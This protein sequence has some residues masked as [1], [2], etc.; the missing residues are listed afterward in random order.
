MPL[1]NMRL[2]R[3]WSQE[4]LAAASG[5]SARTIQ[6]IETG[7]RP[8]LETRKSLAAFDTDVA[9]LQM[10]P[11]MPAPIDP[12][13]ETNVKGLWL[14]LWAFVVVIAA[15]VGLNYV[16]TPGQL[17]VHWVALFWS[18]GV[19]LHVITI[20]VRFGPLIRS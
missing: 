5:L 20:R 18:L 15:L 19:L 2:A 11:A 1:K 14:H 3:G 10:D 17:W 4:D 9:S 12:D 13:R 7:H 16:A 8:G 6:R